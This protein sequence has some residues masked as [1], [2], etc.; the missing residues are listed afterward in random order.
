[1]KKTK[2]FYKIYIRL[3]DQEII[4]D[5][6]NEKE[7]IPFY[8]PFFEQKQNINRSSMLYSLNGLMQFFHAYVANI[9]LFSKSVIDPK[10]AL[11]CVDLFS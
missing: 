1:M 2:F 9:H 4:Y 5:D 7:R 6:N 11:L 10:Y 8:P 3:E